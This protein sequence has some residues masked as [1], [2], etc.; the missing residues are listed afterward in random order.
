MKKTVGTVFLILTV[1][2]GA[3]FLVPDLR[4]YFWGDETRQVLPIT[5]SMWRDIRT[6]NFGFWN[7]TMSFGASNAIHFLSYLGSPTFWLFQLLPNAKAILD[8]LP[9]V[10]ILTLTAAGFF[11]YLWLKD[12]SKD[13]FAVFTGTIIMVFSGWLIIELHYYSYVDAWMYLCLLLYSM[14]EFLQGRKK[15]LFPIVIALITIL[16]LFTMYM[17]SWLILFYMITRIWMQK[18]Q[19]SVSKTLKRLMEP[20]L[21]YLLGLGIAGVVFILDADILLSSGRVG[22]EESSS[23]FSVQNLLVSPGGFYRLITSLFSPVINDYDHNI[24]SSPFQ[25]GTIHTYALYEYSFILWPLLIPQ[26]W[27]VSFPGKKTLVRMLAVLCICSLLPLCY[28]L[29]NGNN[30]GR[31]CFYFIIFNVMCIVFLLEQRDNL[32][33]KLLKRSCYGVIGLLV[34]FSVIAFVVHTTTRTNQI[35]IL[36]IVPCLILLTIGY[37]FTLHTKRQTLFQ[38]LLVAEALLCLSVRIVNGRTITIGKGERSKQYEASLLDTHITD[39][40]QSEDQG[41]YRISTDE[42]VAENY[43]LPMAKGYKSNSLYFSL[44]NSA[45]AGYYQGRITDSWFIPFLPSKFLSYSVFGNKYL[46]LYDENSFV[47]HGYTLIKEETSSDGTPV[48][49]YQN[50]VD[51]GLGYASDV[52]VDRT[53]SDSVDKSVQ[54]VLLASGIICERR[55]DEGNL[56][57]ALT[58]IDTELQDLGTVNNAVLEHAFTEPGTLYID[59]SNTQPY[60]AGSYELYRDGKVTAYQEFDEFSY[61][62]I[63]LEE[64]IDGIGIYTHNTNFESELTDVHVYWLPDQALDRIYE[65]LNQ[66]DHIQFL[67]EQKGNIKASVTI[68]D[69]TKMVATSVPYNRG[70]TVLV[71]GKP[72][73]YELVNLGFIGFPLEPGEHTLEFRFLPEYFMI[74]CAVSIISILIYL[75]LFLR[76]IRDK[77]RNHAV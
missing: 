8:T 9:L 46:V 2:F 29:F 37:T 36:T 28:V 15:L 7:W 77:R 58:D 57:P 5:I 65:N 75:V 16:D 47:P 61:Y 50:R 42:S 6:G 30:A 35:S 56:L 60:S 55:A 43:N 3:L 73:D 10:N 32:D 23:F 64:P 33:L 38:I 69:T 31:W 13:E 44:Y 54:D 26:L 24:F 53:Y 25:E 48:R 52:C 62:A 12:L 27:K 71:D 40:I 14:E 72:I 49:V 4:Y 17:A 22:G 20:F 11:S 76:T 67:Q 34:L 74:G 51:L 45:S 18:E 59:Y 39:Q 1:F 66:Q 70:W 21:Y 41:F 19:I 68:S 63:H